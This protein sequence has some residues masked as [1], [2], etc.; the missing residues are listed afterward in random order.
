MKNIIVSDSLG[1]SIPE[2]LQL[3]EDIWD[4]LADRSESV[5]LTEEEKQ[6]INKRLQAYRK[7][8]E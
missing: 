3:V 2:T 4:I 6:R 5:K 8:S 1:L 7:N